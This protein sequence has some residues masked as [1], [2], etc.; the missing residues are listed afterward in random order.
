MPTPCDFYV[1]VPALENALRC[2]MGFNSCVHVLTLPSN[3]GKTTAARHVARQ[4][5]KE[6]RISGFVYADLRRETSQRGTPS[7][8]LSG[9]F[10]DLLRVDSRLLFREHHQAHILPAASDERPVVFIGDGVDDA[11]LRGSAMQKDVISLATSSVHSKRFCVLLLFDDAEKA[12]IVSTWNGGQKIFMYPQPHEDVEL[13]RPSAGEVREA[14]KKQQ[15]TLDSYALAAFTDLAV[16][17]RSVGFVGDGGQ[18][19][20]A[21]QTTNSSPLTADDVHRWLRP[22]F[23]RQKA[24]W[25]TWTSVL[26]RV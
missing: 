7:A 1:P 21:L 16:Q 25:Q 26:K 4:L 23:D 22:E 9:L 11:V 13:Y 10:A 3:N 17:T 18:I 5:L 2:S 12:R 8:T 20:R 19:V 24:A 14:V 6:D 15:L